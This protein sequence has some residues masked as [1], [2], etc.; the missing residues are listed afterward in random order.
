[1]QARPGEMRS[2]FNAALAVGVASLA[3]AFLIGFGARP[4]ILLSHAG[5]DD[6]LFVRLA[7]SLAAAQWLGP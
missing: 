1:M 7:R 5:L 4:A 6:A 3:A 2:A